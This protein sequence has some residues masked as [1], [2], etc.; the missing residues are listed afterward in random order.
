MPDDDNSAMS[1]VKNNG[2]P[3]TSYG[4]KLRALRDDPA[5]L[6][7]ILMRIADSES[8]TDIARDI[9]IKPWDLSAI[10]HA[11]ACHDDYM[12]AKEYAAEAWAARGYECLLM[13]GQEI[14]SATVQRARYLES[15]CR[16]RAGVLN[17]RYS[18]RQQVEVSGRDGAPLPAAQV[19]VY[20]PDNGRGRVIDGETLDNSPATLD[21][22]T[23]ES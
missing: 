23:G 6:Q 21:N 11:P 1:T 4:G 3:V 14:N 19:V 16:W 2:L 18:E 8:L 22:I 12:R 13:D 5:R 9:G 15:H 17:T 7:T 20:L 10:L